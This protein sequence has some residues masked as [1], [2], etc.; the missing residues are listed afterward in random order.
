MWRNG[1]RALP[2]NVFDD[3]VR[4]GKVGFGDR[5]PILSPMALP[6]LA[7]IHVAEVAANLLMLKRPKPEQ[8]A[9]G[10]GVAHGSQRA[11]SA[12]AKIIGD[13]AEQIALR[14]ITEKL[15]GVSGVVHVAQL[16]ETPGWDIQFTDVD[17]SVVAIEVK[18]ATGAAFSNFELTRQELA[19]A[20]KLKSRYW[21]YLVSGCT[22][23]QPRLLRIQDPQALIEEGV[24][25]LEPLV[26]SVWH[27]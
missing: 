23:L 9:G 4:A 27:S 6:D 24:L 8:G 18:G 16:G 20:R 25:E 10:A 26:W 1:V 11:R 5:Q 14:F 3:I 7:S 17:G 12:N 2:K 22:G 13:R 21:I 15:Q 19:A